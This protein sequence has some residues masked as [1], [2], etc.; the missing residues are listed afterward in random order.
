MEL[1]D[2]EIF[3]ALAE[4]LHFGRA[5]Q[6]LHLSQAR[7]SQSIKAQ[8]RYYGATLVDRANRRDIRL[9]P[10]G[11]QLHADLRPAHRALLQA[12]ERA[13]RV[14]ADRSGAGSGNTF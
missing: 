10:L 11:Q 2:I 4:E 5:A 12:Q 13:R 14:A 3:L 6:R 7:I 9:T 1:R 8:E